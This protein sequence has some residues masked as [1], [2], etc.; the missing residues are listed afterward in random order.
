[1]ESVEGL[2]GCGWGR[3]PCLFTSI[4]GGDKGC[5]HMPGGTAQARP[6]SCFRDL[7]GAA[8]HQHIGQARAARQRPVTT[9]VSARSTSH[10]ATRGDIEGVGQISSACASCSLTTECTPQAT[11]SRA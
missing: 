1:M 5:D 9:T 4:R 10:A 3:G 11:V 6:N 2:S 8:V 7:S